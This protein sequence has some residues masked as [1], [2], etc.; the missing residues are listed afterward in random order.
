VVELPAPFRRACRLRRHLST[1][2]I[3]D[4]DQFSLLGY[5]DRRLPI[6]HELPTSG[7]ETRSAGSYRDQWIERGDGELYGPALRAEP[8]HRRESR[9]GLGPT[10]GWQA[11]LARVTLDGRPVESLGPVTL[12]ARLNSSLG[13]NAYHA[14]VYKKGAVVLDMLARLYGEDAFLDI[15]RELVRVVEGRV[16]STDDFL[17]LLERI[18][19]V[20]LDWFRRQYVYGTGLPE[21][22]Y[23]YRIEELGGGR[24]AIDGGPAAEHRPRALL[25]SGEPTGPSTSPGGPSRA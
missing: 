9:V 25:R 10:S 5:E 22:F 4:W 18:G 8:A 15:L 13:G 7:G 12:G 24:W 14:I 19:G 2:G 1:A 6:A 17:T 11:E 21:I 16:I 23:D 20:E 3:V